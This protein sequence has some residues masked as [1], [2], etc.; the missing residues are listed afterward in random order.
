MTRALFSLTL[1]G[2]SGCQLSAQG[3]GDQLFH[4]S[5]FSGSKFNTWSC[6]TC[7]ATTDSDARQLSGHP[8]AGVTERPSYWGG[9]SPRLIDAASFCYVYFMRGPKAF[10]AGEP[11]SKALYEYLASL[12]GPADARPYTVVAN[13]ADVPR[14]DG[15]RGEQVYASAC[16]DCHGELHTGQGANSA[17]ASV[18]PE[19]K[20][21]YAQI[22][23]GVEPSLV[24]I[25]KVRHGQFFGVGGNMPPFGLERLS[26]EDLGALLK[27]LGL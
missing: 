8:L 15:A 17:L 27:Y 4:D 1:L 20:D 16:R 14:G 18:L 25:E 11:R 19:V 5:Q 12:S 10:E 2:L 26:D 21:E 9:N 23:P 13:L 6:A 3:Y 7:H 24:F 22:F